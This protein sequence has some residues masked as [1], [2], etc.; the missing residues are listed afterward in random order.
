MVKLLRVVQIQF[1]RQTVQPIS[2]QYRLTVKAISQS[3]ST[4]P[5]HSATSRTTRCPNLLPTVAVQP[6]GTST[7][8]SLN[9]FL[10][11]NQFIAVII[12]ISFNAQT[13][14]AILLRNF[15]YFCEPNVSAGIFSS[16]FLK[17][18]AESST[19]ILIYQDFTPWKDQNS[20]S[21]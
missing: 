16:D 17:V 14:G 18:P 10:N 11:L 15:A 4:K 20:E 2:P 13:I 9:K 12:E 19:S 5:Y 7:K 3:N 1:T 8:T 6:S 21:K